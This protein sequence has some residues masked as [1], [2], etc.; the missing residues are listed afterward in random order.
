MI[1]YPI[2]ERTYRISANTFR[3]KYSFLKVEIQ[4]SKYIRPKVTVH[5]CAETI[6][7]QKLYEEIRQLNNKYDSNLVINVYS[8]W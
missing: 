3:G 7:G 8:V 1:G 2:K 4:R 6:H 5:K